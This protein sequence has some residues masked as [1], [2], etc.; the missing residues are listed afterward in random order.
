ME[1]PFNTTISGD[2]LKG[3]GRFTEG[4]ASWPTKRRWVSEAFDALE[5]AGY[6][7]ISAYTAVKDA[8]RTRFVY[9]DR[10]WQGADLAGLG[11]ASFGHVNGVHVQNLD[12]WEAY[13][14]AVREGRLPLSRAYRPTGEERLIREFIL[15]LKRGTVRTPYFKDKF[16]VDVVERFR[17]QLTGLQ[18]DGMLRTLTDDTIALTREGLLQVDGVLRRF[19]LPEHAGVR[20]S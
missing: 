8:A 14:G 1:L 2:L 15:Q 17:P 6:T 18:A 9:T 4:P 16:G 12:S 11:V 20:Y 5:G 7:V 19:F 3:A 13:S 10:V